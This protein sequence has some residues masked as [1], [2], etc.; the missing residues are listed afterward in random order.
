MAKMVDI[1]N[2]CGDPDLV[3]MFIGAKLRI[4]KTVTS[5]KFGWGE[6]FEER[7]VAQAK[8]LQEREDGEGTRYGS[9]PFFHWPDSLSGFIG[10]VT[11]I[12]RETKSITM[13]VLNYDG[14]NQYM[15]VV[16]DTLTSYGYDEY[17]DTVEFVGDY[18]ELRPAG[19]ES[20]AEE[21][22]EPEAVSEEDEVVEEPEEP[23]PVFE[24]ST[25]YTNLYRMMPHL[26][27]LCSAF[28][29]RLVTPKECSAPNAVTGELS[30]IPP[31]RNRLTE[32][33]YSAM[34]GLCPH[35]G[36]LAEMAAGNLVAPFKVSESLMRLGKDL[37]AF[38]SADAVFVDPSQEARQGAYNTHKSY[39]QLAHYNR[40]NRRALEKTGQLD[41]YEEAVGVED[42]SI[43]EVGSQTD[44]HALFNVNRLDFQTLI[45]AAE[46][47]HLIRW[48]IISSDSFRGST[49][50]ND[51]P[52]AFIRQ[53]FKIGSIIRY[54]NPPTDEK[55]YLQPPP[56]FAGLKPE[57]YTSIIGKVNTVT[58]NTA[59]GGKERGVFVYGAF[60][61]G[62]VTVGG[63]AFT[64]DLDLIH[65]GQW[66]MRPTQL[67]TDSDPSKKKATLL[68]EAAADDLTYQLSPE[69]RLFYAPF[70][71]AGVIP[72]STAI[73]SM[74]ERGLRHGQ[75]MTSVFIRDDNYDVD[76][77]TGEV[78][79]MK[80]SKE[81][82][83][84]GV[85]E[86]LIDIP[87]M[88][89][90]QRDTVSKLFGFVYRVPPE[91]FVS[92]EKPPCIDDGLRHLIS[93]V[94][95]P[96]DKEALPT[97]QLIID[98]KATPLS[99]YGCL[100]QLKDT[101]LRQK[102]MSQAMR[103]YFGSPISFF[104][105]DFST[106]NN[107]G[108]L[109]EGPLC[110]AYNVRVDFDSTGSR[111]LMSETM[112]M[113]EKVAL[114]TRWKCA[115]C[116]HDNSRLLKRCAKCKR[117][118]RAPVLGS[119][120]DPSRYFRVATA[121]GLETKAVRSRLQAKLKTQYQ[122]E[123]DLIDQAQELLEKKNKEEK[124]ARLKAKALAAAEQQN[125]TET[126]NKVKK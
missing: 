22:V 71:N 92:Q 108:K 53:P 114:D 1:Y 68:R 110:S 105:C 126:K 119:G 47:F 57:D 87:T 48:S 62:G 41:Q 10:T 9:K 37:V 74:L 91:P 2:G 16:V 51:P 30:V 24:S 38:S 50:T 7:L 72:M 95:K 3:G 83:A 4:K 94:I 120:G 76:L 102:L 109:M 78:R 103:L 104:G 61:H 86:D 35:L 64:S 122:Q 11:E 27:H 36:K 75:Q 8:D 96:G 56:Q 98:G 42:V 106:A 40:V 17:P 113:H 20:E 18:T 115:S 80:S 14:E 60:T 77:K 107:K 45:N 101:K 23:A 26:Y 125:Q 34:Q 123:L 12:D 100:V 85:D 116:S 44:Y 5:P 67:W 70:N 82:H 124:A 15:L 43:L 121:N 89:R 73:A 39:E 84:L 33:K 25:S 55:P 79:R 93:V 46:P 81:L 49:Y 118:R 90:G 52:K 99:F 117:S 111:D 112:K 59:P 54:R 65:P 21:E 13:D 97:G 69:E 31:L 6:D 28:E 58:M 19:E 66:F 29:P 63:A 32:Q 88:N